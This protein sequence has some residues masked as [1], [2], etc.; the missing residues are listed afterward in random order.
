MNNEA[1]AWIATGIAVSV[2]IFI[3]GSAWCLWALFIP[4]IFF[5]LMINED[6]TEDCYE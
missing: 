4:A 6:L 2:G 1:A 3:T 5:S